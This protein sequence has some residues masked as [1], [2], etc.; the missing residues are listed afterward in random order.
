MASDYLLEIDGIEGESTDDKHP[1]AIEVE[2]WS[3]GA[4]NPSSIG[5]GGLGSGKVSVQDFTFTHHVDAASPVL[6]LRC[7]TGQHIK[8]A[9]LFVRKTGGGGEYLTY[10]FTDCL[11]SSFEDKGG[12]EAPTEEIALAFRRIEMEYTVQDA[13]GAA[14]KVIKAGWDLAT[15]KKV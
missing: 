14:G 8:S 13:T 5:S 3:W 4:S 15:N 10:T 12:G 6:F 7:A 9:K 11:V 1:G 2:S